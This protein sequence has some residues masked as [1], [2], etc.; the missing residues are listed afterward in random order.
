[1]GEQEPVLMPP[2]RVS[3][4]PSRGQLAARRLVA[5]ALLAGGFG[6]VA[7]LTISALSGDEG[8]KPK[9][10]PAARAVAR[11]KP[12]RIVFPEG[13]TRRQ[14]AGRI[15]AVSGI[16]K[17][18][19]D[20]TPRLS[21]KGYLAGTRSGRFPRGFRSESKTRSLEGFLFPATYEFDAKTTSAQLVAKQLKAFR[22]AWAQV[23]L[24]Y[25][26]SR[27]LTPY[28]VLTIASMI[29]E[30]VRAPEERRL[31]SAVVYNRLRAGIP[32]GIDATIRYALNVPPTRSL[33]ESHLDSPTPY[34]TRLFQ[35]LPPTP[36][37]NP[38]LAA[39]KAA[40]R[41]ARTNYLYFVRKPDKIHHFFT[42]SAQEHRDYQ[43]A[44]G[45]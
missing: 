34:N 44:N 35:G 24:R 2:R 9:P 11:P 39:M 32:L 22:R 41:P 40:A 30:E 8:E 1:V 23:D 14:M 7:W 38:G 5:L 45:Y 13:F 27:N 18:K 17:R 10:P 36:I 25:A 12:L 43:R 31:V 20:V 37:T 21:A 19:R 42:A 29:E 16:A 3:G 6:A 15:V 4:R 26:R 33:R 28:D